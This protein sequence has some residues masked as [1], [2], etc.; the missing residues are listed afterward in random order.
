MHMKHYQVK[1]K[2][3][4]ILWKNTKCQWWQMRRL[5]IDD[6]QITKL[7][8]VSWKNGCTKEIKHCMTKTKKSMLVD[9]WIAPIILYYKPDSG[10]FWMR[11]FWYIIFLLLARAFAE[12]LASMFKTFA[13]KVA[14]CVQIIDLIKF[15]YAFDQINVLYIKFKF[16]ALNSVNGKYSTHKQISLFWQTSNGK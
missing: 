10:L 12:S 9:L 4:Q 6:R 7:S 14:L 15:H 5:Q 1:L 16:L 3:H 8:S 13:L 11:D 2:M